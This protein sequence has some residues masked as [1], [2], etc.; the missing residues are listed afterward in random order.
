VDIIIMLNLSAVL[1][2]HK[3]NQSDVASQ[4]ALLSQFSQS[5]AITRA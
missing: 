5:E 3:L 2:V 1:S 4:S